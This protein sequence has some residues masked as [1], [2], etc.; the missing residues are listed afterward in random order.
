MARKSTVWFKRLAMV[1]FWLSL[2]FLAY[3][4]VSLVTPRWHITYSETIVPEGYD[5]HG[6]D[7]SHY[8]E[9]IDWKAVSEASVGGNPI[10]FAFI[11]ATMG[12]KRKDK[13]FEENFDEAK[14]KGIIRGAYHYFDPTESAEQQAEHF[15]RTV[16]LAPGD[17]PPVL[18]YEVTKKLTKEEI[19]NTALTWLRI[20]EKRTGVKPIL[21]T[22]L[23]FKQ[24][25]F[26]TKEFD[27]YPFW[28]AHYAFLHQ[29]QPSYPGEWKFWQHTEKG[30]IEGIEGYVDMNVYN[31][32]MFDMRRLLLPE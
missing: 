25:Y 13:R 6:I 27:A 11:R 4:V 29:N 9:E 10:V 19:R 15:L 30:R 7:V 24:D 32:S 26:N 12:A 8:Q 1:A 16:R 17:F 5:L 14:Q 21:Y 31:G 28:I 20:V 23:K 22:Y 2:V 3:Q 18:D